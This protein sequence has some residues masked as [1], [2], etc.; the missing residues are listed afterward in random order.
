VGS[1][2]KV[3]VEEERKKRLLAVVI[4]QWATVGIMCKAAGKELLL[5]TTSDWDGPLMKALGRLKSRQFF[6]SAPLRNLSGRQQQRLEAEKK[7]I[8]HYWGLGNA[9]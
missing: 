2:S 6:H 9:S 1:S 7:E 3:T 8:C 5:M 4:H